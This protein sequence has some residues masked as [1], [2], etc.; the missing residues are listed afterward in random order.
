MMIGERI[1]HIQGTL[2]KAEGDLRAL[3]EQYG[4][5]KVHMS[6]L[7]EENSRLYV[8][9]YEQEQLIT[10]LEEQQLSP[11]ERKFEE[12]EREENRMHQKEYYNEG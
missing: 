6:Q 4:S 5:N 7:R 11:P 2:R 10:F 1:K 9:I 12:A 3:K 8:E